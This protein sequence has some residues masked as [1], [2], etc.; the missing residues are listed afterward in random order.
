MR[1]KKWVKILPTSIMIAVLA[2]MLVLFFTQLFRLPEPFFSNQNLPFFFNTLMVIII[3]VLIIIMRAMLVERAVL[4][5]LAF[6]DGITGLYNRHGLEQFWKTYRSKKSMAILYLDL[7]H[8]KEINDRFG[9]HVGDALL[10]EVSVRLQQVESKKHRELFRLGGDEFVMILK[11]CDP[12]MAKRAATQILEK[13]T[14]PYAV[15][16]YHVLI[17]V[18]I[19]IRMCTARNAEHDMLVKEADAAMYVAKK[20]GKNGFFV[21][22]EGRSKLPKE[23]YGNINQA[24]P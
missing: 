6:R 11:N 4:K 2:G 19:G 22:R 5:K 8:F 14:T 3:T 20:Q 23:K 16:G 18:S 13:L 1:L 21:F 17:T 24:K 9:H 10:R 7:D 15:E 12:I